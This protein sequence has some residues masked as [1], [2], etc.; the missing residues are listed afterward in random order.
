MLY[1]AVL[2]AFS[3]SVFAQDVTVS[4]RVVTA[5]GEPVQGANVFIKGTVVGAS[6]L[7]DGRFS[8]PVAPLGDTVLSIRHVAM[9]PQ[10]IQ[11][12]IS[13][14]MQP[15]VIRLASRA[16]LLREAEVNKRS[17]RSVDNNRSISL[18]TMDVD[19]SPGSD[20]DVTS[21]LRQLPGV[22]TVGE[23]GALFVRG[24]SGV[25]SKTFIDGLEITHPYFTGIPDIAQRSRY[26]P[27]LFE[28]ITFSTGGYAPAYGDALSAI[29]SLDT[30]G[31]PE[32]SATVL[33]LL[34]YGVQVG[35][36]QLFDGKSSAGVDVSY[37]DFDPYY[38]LIHHRTEWVDAPANW[39][40]NANFRHTTAG[41]GMI[42]WYGYG[43]VS[44]QAADLP[45]VNNGGAMALTEV[46]NQNAVSLFTFER[47]LANRGNLYVGYGFNYNQ[48][49][50]HVQQVSSK[51]AQAQHQLRFA[52]R[53]P[54]GTQASLDVGAEGYAVRYGASMADTLFNYRGST[55][56]AFSFSPFSGASIRPGVRMDYSS[57]MVRMAVNPRLTAAYQLSAASRLSLVA[58][59]YAQQP[60]YPYIGGANRLGY[61][62]ADQ[63]LA[64]FQHYQAGRLLRVEAYRK[65]YRGLLSTVGA[66]DNHGK[67]WAQGVDVFWRDHATLEGF[68]YWLSYSYL[69]TTRMY[70]DYPVAAT[71]TFATP[72]T[73][74]VVAKQFIRPLG[75]FVGGS[76]GFATG[77]PYFNPNN[78]VFLGDRTPAYHNVN[79]NAALL[80]KWGN[81]FVTLVAAVNNV[82]GRRHTFGYRYADDGSFRL[83]V[84]IPYGRALLIAAFISFGK[85][86][87]DEILNQLP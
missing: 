76:Y 66:P 60:E 53:A 78:P 10:E 40:A 35:H 37:S 22:Q 4:G 43:N 64:N 85:D 49:R 84:E 38:R 41:G 50:Y 32:K 48:D 55:W 77:R 27:H 31:H 19:T 1:V 46:G 16:N 2:A 24:G 18:T 52:I 68:D 57:L 3:S 79:I 17:H 7:S 39:M 45:N 30:R 87:S 81:A 74:H 75:V 67:G 69:R 61:Q 12:H 70:L 25:E 9:E 13:A 29:L 65:Q 34:P 23:N 47:P 51:T 86:R 15:L 36:D 54:V 14:Q 21:A 72:H 33:A 44:S 11:V 58:G 73:L 56:A 59:R 62:Y 63:Y 26:S 5:I 71:P 80:R 8:F 28:G 82:A 20:G 6:T 42:K 83:P